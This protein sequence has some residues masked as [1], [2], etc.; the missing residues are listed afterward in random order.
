VI[1]A[2]LST[3]E[4]DTV[5]DAIADVMERAEGAYSTVVMTKDRVVAFRDPAGLRPLALG[6]L[7]ERY[8]VASES[9]AFDII[10]AKYLREILPG[11][12]VSFTD[13]GLETRQVVTSDRQAFCVFEHIY[14]SRPDSRVFTRSVDH[15]RRALGRELAREHPAPGADCVFSVPDSSNAMALGYSEASGVKLE[16]ALIRNHYVGRT[17]IQPLQAGRTARVKIKFNPVREVLEGQKVVVVD[18]SIVRGTTSRKI[19]GMVR[20]AGA[21]V[22]LA[23][24]CMRS[25]NRAAPVTSAGSWV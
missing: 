19:V 3:H 25:Q 4:S 16:H 8:C 10:G 24:V 17:F 13:R 5:E 15:V 22:S 14:F 20:A 12:M 18:D 21:K 6:L 11:E 23:L 9:C 1:A 7:G 2:L